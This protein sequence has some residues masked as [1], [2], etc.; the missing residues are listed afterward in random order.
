MDLVIN[1]R[2]LGR[3]PTGVDR[4][5]VEITRA[6][7]T[8]QK[9]EGFDLSVVVPPQTVDHAVA[10]LDGVVDVE[11]VG[12]DLPGHLWE[13]SYL[14]RLRP[15]SWLLG[16]CNTGPIL[17]RKQ[18]VLFHDAQFRTQPESY[19]RAFR[20]TYSVLLPA[21]S[22]RA[23]RACTVSDYSR[24]VLEDER[25]VPPGKLQVIPNGTDHLDRV[26]PDPTV[27]DRHDLSP[28]GYF[29]A[30][31]SL[32]PHKNLQTLYDAVSSASDG[33]SPLVVVGAADPRVLKESS[34]ISSSKIKPV[35]RVTD[36][37][38]KALYEGALALCLPSLTEGFG[39]SAVEAMRCGTPVLAARAGA[40]PEVCGDAAIMVPPTDVSAWRRQLE[41]L[42]AAP[43]LRSA[44]A[45]RGLQHARRFDWQSSARTLTWLLR[46]ADNVPTEPGSSAF[47]DRRPDR[48]VG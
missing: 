31:G 41:R 44:L 11:A 26:V 8:L 45:N 3:P 47:S 7:A 16:L 17:R 19:S 43:E 33:C 5:A 2:F 39:L 42:D 38:L 48:I 36:P 34:R 46:T 12:R 6:L 23:V 14:S 9:V 27:F 20:L 18:A 21:L 40:L 32:A 37:E 30:V 15:H 10:E 25:V 29:L 35:G 28:D 13:Q 22:R 24:R 1:G 4:T